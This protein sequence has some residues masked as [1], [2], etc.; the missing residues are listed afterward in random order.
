MKYIYYCKKCK[1]TNSTE[2]DNSYLQCPECK[3]QMYATHIT[4]DEWETRT[5]ESK[6][7]LKKSFETIEHPVMNPIGKALKTVG[8]VYIGLSVIGSFMMLTE[9]GVAYSALSLI[10]GCLGGLLLLGFA[11]VVNLLQD[12]KNK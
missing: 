10:F 4:A 8:W 11:E 12:I 1:S 5:A 2:N 7:F 6:E 9:V 3:M